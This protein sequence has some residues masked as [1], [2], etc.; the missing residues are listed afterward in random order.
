MTAAEQSV[1]L[2]SQGLSAEAIARQLGVQVDWVRR[3]LL[4][5]GCI[6]PKGKAS[7]ARTMTHMADANRADK[8]LRRF[9]WQ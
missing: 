5:A 7:V 1:E 8:L 4:R 9:S 2:H 3:S 6:R